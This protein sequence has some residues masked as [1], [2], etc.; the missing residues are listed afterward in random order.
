MHPTNHFTAFW[1]LGIVILLVAAA[2][3]TPLYISFASDDDEIYVYLNDIF[4]ICF[5]IDIILNFLTAYVDPD[6]RIVWDQKKI[7]TRYLQSWFTVDLIA[8]L[9]FETISSWIFD[10]YHS[11]D[12]TSQL[13]RLFR[14]PRLIRLLKIFRLIK[15]LKIFSI[16]QHAPKLIKKLNLNITVTKILK[17]F[18]SF[19][20]LNHIVGCLWFFVVSLK[21]SYKIDNLKR[22][23][24]RI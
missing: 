14:I 5:A 23:N 2:I 8:V 16:S 3:L 21:E 11:S 18:L 17:I 12:Q 22:Q 20:F 6:R 13:F 7:A 10:A 24:W 19:V 15:M 9:P 1:T 4:D